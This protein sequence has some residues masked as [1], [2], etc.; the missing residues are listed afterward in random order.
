[1]SRK[2]SI[3]P[4]GPMNRLKTVAWAE[5]SR[6]LPWLTCRAPAP[7]PTPTS[8]PGN[9]PGPTQLV[10]GKVQGRGWGAD[11]AMAVDPRG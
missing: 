3:S 10:P 8:L 7:A 9:R 6:Q 11:A 1:M 2:E 4:L 5:A